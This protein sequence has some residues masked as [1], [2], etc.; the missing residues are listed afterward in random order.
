MKKIVPA[1]LLAFALPVI[2]PAQT[3]TQKANYGSTA[4]YS[5][6]SFSVGGKGYVGTGNSSASSTTFTQELWEYDPVSNAWT[7]KMNFP[8]TARYEA[9]AFSIG[10]YGYAGTG[11]FI[12]A[13]VN[14]DMYRYNPLTNTWSQIAAMP[15]PR[16]C[17]VAF[18]I[19]QKAYVAT[20]DTLGNNS[21]YPSNELWEYN[22]ANDSWT[23]RAALPGVNRSRAF[24]FAVNGKGYLGGGT[25]DGTTNLN[26][27][28]EYDPLLN[29]WVQKLN[30]PT[31]SRLPVGFGI[32]YRGFY[33]T[34]YNSSTSSS[35]TQLYEYDPANNSW[36]ARSN[37][38]GHVR[39]GAV[40]FVI[41]LN[42]F[43]GCGRD[44][45][46]NYPEWWEYIDAALGT[47]ELSRENSVSVY[48][49]PVTT[50][51]TIRLPADIETS[52]LTF[53]IFDMNGKLLKK[54]ILKG[55][56]FFS[57]AAL[58]NGLYMYRVSTNEK[59]IGCGKLVLE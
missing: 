18:V 54:E 52:Q 30:M 23:A 2:A 1:F 8:G 13:L 49:N 3:W 41:G 24:A 38:G 5:S 40:S 6:F 59:T 4:T 36:T 42:A 58:S 14:S 47:V 50:G 29:S 19:G 48:P 53:E 26:D 39:W 55:D 31:A 34:G 46:S 17:A 37:Y 35:S 11:S 56:F 28:W 57:R 43:V 16:N 7:Q 27:F 21:S 9:I 45:S 44:G 25:T 51:A 20:G 10:N 12:N 32:G 15:V 33:C 22:P